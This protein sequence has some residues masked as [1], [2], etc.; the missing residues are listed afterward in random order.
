MTAVVD[1]FG[2]DLAGRMVKA[3]GYLTVYF[4]NY[5]DAQEHR[6]RRAA[7]GFCGSSVFPEHSGL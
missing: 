7:G 1:F 4:A 2:H 6:S 5:A 3:T